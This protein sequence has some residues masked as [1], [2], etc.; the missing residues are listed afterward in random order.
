M[1]GLFSNARNI[2]MQ[3]PYLLQWRVEFEILKLD[4]EK[5]K[6]LYEIFEIIAVRKENVITFH[7]LLAFLEVEPT[8]FTQLVFRVMDQDDDGSIDFRE[9]V[10]ALWNYCTL[11]KE[12][13]SEYIFIITYTYAYMCPYISSFHI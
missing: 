8:N 13:L 9:F 2:Y 6:R 5:I 10:H 7:E 4:P 3:E 1:G 12:A 11:G